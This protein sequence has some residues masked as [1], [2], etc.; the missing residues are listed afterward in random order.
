MNS[1]PCRLTV[2]AWSLYWCAGGGLVAA[3]SRED[4]A[5]TPNQPATLPLP[6]NQPPRTAP[7]MKRLTDSKM[8]Q[9]VRREMLKDF[10][11]QSQLDLATVRS[12][13]AGLYRVSIKRRPEPVALD[14]PQS[15]VLHVETPDGKP[16][17][18]AVL[19]FSGGMPQHG[20]GFPTRPRVTADLGGG[21]Y[22]VEGVQFSMP[23][24]WQFDVYVSKARREDT[25][26]F[27][28]IIE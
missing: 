13:R 21:D 11:P 27:D 12:S 4:S 15:W 2:L 24:W 26:S 7:Y 6:Q 8:Y 22:R 20:H 1:C 14:E 18:G 16:L 25:V 5:Q 19:S 10:D 23:G 17:T 28:L 3:C 9:Y